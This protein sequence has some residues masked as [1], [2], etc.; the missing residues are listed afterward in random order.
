[1]QHGSPQGPT[2]P[3]YPYAAGLPPSP[4]SNTGLIVA[5]VV[6]V[7]FVVVGLVGALAAVGFASTRKYLS[8][9]KSAEATN[10]VAQI[11]RSA[12][13]AYERES[14]VGESATP[15]ALCRSALRPVPRSVIAVAGKKYMSNATEWADGDTT[16]GWQCL[17][18]EMSS[19]QYY[20]YDYKATRG[21]F[22]ALAHGD[23]D[24]DGTTSTFR[25]SGKVVGGSVV[26]DPAVS[27]S[28]PDE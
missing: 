9:A 25:M 11:G 27:S 28:Q 12:A 3:P 21:S 15:P 20:Q 6:G 22:D 16:T 10:A 2:P 18:F 1:M 23:L 14:V 5:I 24:G 17:R 26:L 13:A 7:V 4:K 19:P 8:A